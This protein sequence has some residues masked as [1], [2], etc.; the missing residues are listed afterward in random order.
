MAINTNCPVC[1]TAYDLV[2]QGRTSNGVSGDAC[3]DGGEAT[4]DGNST[5]IR[6]MG[7]NH[8]RI[9]SLKSLIK[10]T[11]VTCIISALP[12]DSP[13][14]N[15]P[16]NPGCEK[17]NFN[18]AKAA[19]H[20]EAKGR[21]ISI[22]NRHELSLPAPPILFHPADLFTASDNAPTKPSD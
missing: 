4:R 16:I 20:L 18:W 5:I 12:P 6:F 14:D 22:C 19:V 15:E 11:S 9:L 13:H 2:E 3:S 21:T 1:Q 10:R 17:G 7:H 8:F